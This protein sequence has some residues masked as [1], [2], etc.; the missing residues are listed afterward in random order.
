MNINTCVI[1]LMGGLD[2][3]QK[4]KLFRVAS[5]T[6]VQFRAVAELLNISSDELLENLMAEFVSSVQDSIGN[7]AQH[8]PAF[9]E[10]YPFIQ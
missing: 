3:T 10:K 2:I 1:N 4:M 7:I 9:C 6:G 8:H 5:D